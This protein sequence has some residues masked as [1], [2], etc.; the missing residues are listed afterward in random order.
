M[1]T[2]HLSMA[3]CLILMMLAISACTSEDTPLPT[4][5][6]A[7]VPT[8]DEP[9][10][11]RVGTL[12]DLD[13]TNP[14]ACAWW[15]W[16]TEGYIYESFTLYGPDCEL[17]PVLAKS[18]EL[19][20]D[21]LTWTIELQEGVTYSDGEPFNAFTLNDFWEWYISV[22]P[23][24]WYPSGLYTVSS[25]AVDETT[26]QIT[27]EVPLGAF[28]VYDSRFQVPYPAHVWSEFDDDTLWD[29]ENVPPIGTGPYVMT[30]W[31]V[32]EYFI[33]EARD[34]YWGGDPPI[35]RVV[36][37]LYSNWDALV[38]ALIAGEIDLTDNALPVQFFDTLETDS[39]VTVVSRPPGY[40]YALYFNVAE[41]GIKHVAIDDPVV[42]E[43]IDYAI[44]RQQLIDVA[45]LGH[46]I[47]C[48]TDWACGP[49]IEDM[50]DPSLTV[51]P[52]DPE[53]ANGILDDAGYVDSDGDGIR[54]TPDGKPLILRLYFDVDHPTQF[55]IAELLTQWLPAVGIQ[56]ESE[57][58][59][60]GTLLSSLTGTRDFDMFILYIVGEVLPQNVD[61]YFSCWSSEEAEGTF[62]F[63]GYCDEEFDGLI[64]ELLE[65]VDP[66][67]RQLALNRVS[68]KLNQTRPFVM[69]AGENTMQAYRNDQFTFQH[70]YCPGT[71]GMWDWYSLLNAEVV[72]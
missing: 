30:E 47:Q 65:A 3:I 9:V 4:E 69:L 32:G 1:R 25:E 22:E 5:P 31:E 29:Y 51:T 54:E 8:V 27:M 70:N 7:E 71:Q 37:Q 72:E 17:T 44:D 46:G 24:G 13:C 61:F 57:G 21:G 59:E 38:S 15:W 34:D 67:D 56:V 2:T 50:Q 68:Q 16:Y 36:I 10:T 35:D 28:D 41:A 14:F 11:L 12:T 20:E 42:R 19:S 43:A 6:T 52:Y 40:Y 64:I 33:L 23:G 66:A 45:L 63:S 58:F 18:M 49:F 60:S 26:F 55:T 48:P 62:N 39:S 53:T